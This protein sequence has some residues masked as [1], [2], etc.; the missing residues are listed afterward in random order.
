MKTSLRHTSL[1]LLAGLTAA[2][3]LFAADPT[4]AASPVT[5]VFFQ[6]EKY[7]DLKDGYSDNENTNGR[8]RYLP[9]IEEYLQREAGRLLTAGQKLTVTFTDIDLAGDYEPWHGPQF[10]SVRMVKGVYVPRLTFKFTLAD[11]SGKVIKEG[12]RKLVDLAFQMRVT[13]GFK[14]DPL[15]Y[16]KEMLRDWARDELRPGRS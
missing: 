16:E 2:G 9:Q 13:M 8:E 6:P 15:R 3:A 10:D 11:S 14:D 5:V 4:P 1:A 7:I 12:E